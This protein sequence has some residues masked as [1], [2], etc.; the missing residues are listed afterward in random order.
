[1]SE[2]ILLHICCGI[3]ASGVVGTLREEDFEIFGFFYNPNI[4]PLEEYRKR[5]AVAKEV[6]RILDFPLIEGEYNYKDWHILT[7]DF[8]NEPERGKR[9]DICF[10]MR[11]D[12]T[13]NKALGLNIPFFTTTLTISPYKDALRIFS[14]GKN[15]SPSGFL[16]R[17]FKQRG[18]FKRTI[19][20]SKRYNLYRQNYC[21]CIYSRRKS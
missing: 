18:G 2:R 17:D 16:F 5:L 8:K 10:K 3:C 19:D 6:S 11:L 15:I 20:F 4:H 7:E 12:K 13:W 14:L 9:C 1:M 21:G